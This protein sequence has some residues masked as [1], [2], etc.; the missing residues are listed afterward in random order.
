MQNLKGAAADII[1]RARPGIFFLDI[2]Y[3]TPVKYMMA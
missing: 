2:E 3:H 1:M